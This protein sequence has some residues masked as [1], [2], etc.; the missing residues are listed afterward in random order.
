MIERAVS[1]FSSI[2]ELEK[3]FAEDGDGD[4]LKN[5]LLSP[6]FGISVEKRE[7]QTPLERIN[8][9]AF[10]IRFWRL[11]SCF[12]GLELSLARIYRCE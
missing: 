12:G 7:S 1:M 9:F 5:N 2:N 4:V 3:V 6:T 10:L 8:Q 11:A